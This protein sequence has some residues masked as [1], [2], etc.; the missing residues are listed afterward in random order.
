MK[1]KYHIQCMELIT[2]LTCLPG[3]NDLRSVSRSLHL[4]EILPSREHLK[5]SHFCCHDWKSCYRHL[6]GR[7][8]T[9]YPILHRTVPSSLP[10][11]QAPKNYPVSMVM[12]EVEKPCPTLLILR[13]ASCTLTALHIF[14]TTST[15]PTW[16]LECYFT[17]L[18]FNFYLL[19]LSP[20]LGC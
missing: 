14:N 1:W 5:M 16:C 4:W 8:Y 19:V 9:N 15:E 6:V 18:I 17:T 13:F 10:P 7:G 11:T 2:S 20:L 12:A 3:G